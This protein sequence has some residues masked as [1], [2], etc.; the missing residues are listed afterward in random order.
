MSDRFYDSTTA[1]Q[2][3]GRGFDLAMVRQIIACAVGETT[4][5][6]TLLLMVP[7]RR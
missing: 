7:G 3:Y 5:D 4:P 2:G 6:L 1:Y